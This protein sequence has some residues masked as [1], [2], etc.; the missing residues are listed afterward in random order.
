MKNSGW[1]GVVLAGGQ[2]SRMGSDKAL[3]QIDG[4]S[5]LDRAL[6]RLDR[7]VS[8]FLVIGDPEKYGHIGPFV[9]ADNNPGNGPL[10]GI[11]TAMRYASNDNLL[12]LACDMPAVNDKLLE[13]LK[14]RLGNFT[15]AV[16]PVHGDH[17]EPLCAAYHRRCSS[18]FNFALDRGELKMQMVLEKI[19]MDRLEIILGDGTWPTDLFRNLNYPADL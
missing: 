3:I 12:V 17:V 6:D 1:T 13:L 19:R 2:S 8:E 15:D 7:H 18:I 4:R 16:V 10:G 9:F 11:T 5:L 14:S